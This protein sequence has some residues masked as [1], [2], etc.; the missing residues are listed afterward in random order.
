MQNE[1]T[2]K[3]V[4]ISNGFLSYEIF[5][6]KSDFVPVMGELI[7]NQFGFNPVDLPAIGLSEVVC[8]VEFSGVKL[9]LGWDNWSGAYV[10]A[11]CAKGDEFI[12][13]IASYL[14]NVI[15]HPQYKKYAN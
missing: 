7:Q 11:H 8:E 15:E 1:L 10:M 9:G 6:A 5:N 12:K 14:N 2:G 3:I 4:T 13:K